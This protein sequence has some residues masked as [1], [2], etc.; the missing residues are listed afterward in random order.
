MLAALRAMVANR[1]PPALASAALGAIWNLPHVLCLTPRCREAAQRCLQHAS[2]VAAADAPR[3]A[4]P[5]T[6]SSMPKRGRAGLKSQR[7]LDR[8][9]LLAEP[10][11][12][13][14]AR[15]QGDRQRLWVVHRLGMRRC[16]CASVHPGVSRLRLQRRCMNLRRQNAALAACTGK[17]GVSMRLV[18]WPRFCKQHESV[19][20]EP[21]RHDCRALTCIARRPRSASPP[22]CTGSPDRGSTPPPS[23]CPTRSLPHSRL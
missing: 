18:M 17:K 3:A 1:S 13:H 23:P 9:V 7:H 22:P 21:R 15:W 11:Y 5:G 10:P 8:D 16:P 2:T 19:W 14:R 12:V 4:S 6:C 20:V